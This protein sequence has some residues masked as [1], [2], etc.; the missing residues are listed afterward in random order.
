MPAFYLQKKN[1]YKSTSAEG[2]SGMGKLC[3]K[4]LLLGAVSLGDRLWCIK[5]Y[6]VVIK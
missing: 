1:L 6:Q 5:Y 4:Y 2:D 3:V